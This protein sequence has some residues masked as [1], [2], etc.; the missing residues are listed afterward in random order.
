[1]AGTQTKPVPS[2]TNASKEMHLE[3][4]LLM[5]VSFLIT[6]LAKCQFISHS[7]HYHSPPTSWVK[8]HPN[9]PNILITIAVMISCTSFLIQ[10]D[11]EWILAWLPCI[12]ISWLS[13]LIHKAMTLRYVGGCRVATSYPTL[14]SFPGAFDVRRKSGWWI[15]AALRTTAK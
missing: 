5:H 6:S 7:Q 8:H 2:L 15:A 4:W 3:W 11:Q 14:R 9:K 1:M 13:S 10:I 12:Y